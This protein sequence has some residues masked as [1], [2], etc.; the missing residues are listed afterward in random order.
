MRESTGKVVLNKGYEG[1]EPV[2]EKPVHLREIRNNS[3][4]NIGHTG[5][6]DDPWNPVYETLEEKSDPTQRSNGR[7]L[8]LVIIVC[9]ISLAAFLLTLLM[10]FGKM[11][12]KCE[13]STN[14][15]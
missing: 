10:L 15:G 7:Y 2:A 5:S 11:G 4:E 6:A 3:Q 9:L 1:D 13:C 14:E 12:E 8:A